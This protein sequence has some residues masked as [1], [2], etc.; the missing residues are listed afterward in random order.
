MARE[1]VEV[2]TCQ[3]RLIVSGVRRDRHAHAG[4]RAYS[5]EISYS[6]F[7]RAVEL[8][9]ELEGADVRCEFRDGMLLVRILCADAD[10]GR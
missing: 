9:C 5:L 7:E 4:M 1:E 10:Q 3:R 8:P 6:R 2:R